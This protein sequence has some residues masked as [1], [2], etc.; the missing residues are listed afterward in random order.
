M[1]YTEKSK[2]Y[3]FLVKFEVMMD[4][5]LD[6][7]ELTSVREIDK[8]PA[9]QLEAREKRR[10]LRTE[11]RYFKDEENPNPFLRKQINDQALLNSLVE[12]LV[13]SNNLLQLS[14]YKK[15][16]LEELRVLE[17]SLNKNGLM[18]K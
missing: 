7:S 10:F 13:K 14:T 16:R 9:E 17:M 1:K 12:M 8:I 2:T 4:S 6:Q 18:S 15:D 11:Q 3:E 5:A